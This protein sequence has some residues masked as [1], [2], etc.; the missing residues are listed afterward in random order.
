MNVLRCAQG[1]R[2]WLMIFTKGGFTNRYLI[3]NVLFE[4]QVLNLSEFH[5][6]TKTSAIWNKLYR[7]LNIE[8][9][10]KL[11]YSQLYQSISSKIEV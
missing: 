7:A 2:D 9:G 3:L 1:G 8:N 5:L 6:K 4:V 11:A 10:P